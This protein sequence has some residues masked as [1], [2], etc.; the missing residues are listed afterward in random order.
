MF[1]M[2][3]TLIAASS[4][5]EPASHAFVAN[6]RDNSLTALDVSDYTDIKFVSEL[7]D[8]TDLAYPKDLAIDRANKVAY[9]ASLT[10]GLTSV[11]IDNPSSM[12]VLDNIAAYQANFVKLDLDHNLAF[13]TGSADVYIF[14]ISDSSALVELTELT[15]ASGSLALTIDVTNEVLYVARYDGS[16]TDVYAYNYSNPSGISLLGSVEVNAGSLVPRAFCLGPD[17]QTL[18]ALGGD[19]KVHVIDVSDPAA[20]SLDFSTSIANS[21]GGYDATYLDDAFNTDVILLS[22]LTD[23]AIIAYDASTLSSISEIDR[24]SGTTYLNTARSHAYDPISGVVYVTAE[25]GDEITAYSLA[26][27]VFT[28]EDNYSSSTQLNGASGVALL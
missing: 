25:L 17:M 16:A 18:F 8:G 10:S 3:S 22:A 20:M 12:A 5:P 26:A 23:D 6:Y 2:V 11:N 15:W 24:E 28:L 4:K 13:V 14:D 21:M 27:G 9:V 7:T 1:D 19:G